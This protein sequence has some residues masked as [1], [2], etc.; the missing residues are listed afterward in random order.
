MRGTKYP[1]RIISSCLRRY[2]YPRNTLKYCDILGP[3]YPPLMSTQSGRLKPLSKHVFLCTVQHHEHR[4]RR[5]SSRLGEGKNLHSPK[6]QK[7]ICVM[8]NKTSTSHSVQDHFLPRNATARIHGL[9]VMAHQFLIS[10]EI[11]KFI[12]AS[13]QQMALKKSYG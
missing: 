10:F 13:K 5:F 4:Q 11:C 8:G 12:L 7:G 9:F 1:A 2:H 6:K 3:Y